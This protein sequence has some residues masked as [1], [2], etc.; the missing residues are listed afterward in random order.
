MTAISDFF[1]K[2]LSGIETAYDQSSFYIKKKL[3]LLGP[4]SIQPYLGF[5][6]T[7]KVLISGRLLESE[8]QEAPKENA[9]IWSNIRTMYR[10]YESD[11]VPHARIKVY[12]QNLEQIVKTDSEGYFKLMLEDF[13]LDNENNW[14]DIHFELLDEIYPDQG[15]VTA[16]GKVLIPDKCEYGIIS[17]VDDTILISR[18]SDLI[19]K[20]QL[21][22]F[23]NARTRTPF[24][25][26]SALYKALQGGSN[27]QQINPVF[28]VSSSPWNLYDLL[29]H[30]C[31]VHNIP[32]GP[33]LLRDMGVDSDTFIKSSHEKH[34]VAQIT[35]LFTLY[36]KTKFILIGDSGQKD[37]EIYEFMSRK[38]PKNIQAIYIRDVTS[39]K[40]D[41]EVRAIAE[42]VKKQGIDMILAK[43]ST[44]AA[45]HAYENGLIPR[46]AAEK[47]ISSVEIEDQLK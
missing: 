2:S 38:Y 47:I 21:T 45:L 31:D 43:N 40:R 24:S 29:Y 32:K 3:H 36:P 7:D 25:G 34:K 26:V 11:E 39:D 35:T 42:K 5:G 27:G 1:L 46:D 10:R 16:D 13:E 18:S 28:Y 23:N 44:N 37:P 19:K 12:F 33:F 8:G 9:S 41:A 20:A 30:F 6:S 14:H 17:D 22:F 4:L 15:P